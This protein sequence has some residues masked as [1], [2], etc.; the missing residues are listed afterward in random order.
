MGSVPGI[1]DLATELGEPVGA[2]Q[3]ARF[4]S[5]GY[6]ASSIDAAMSLGVCF[7]SSQTQEDIDRSDARMIIEA[8]MAQ[9]DHCERQLIGYGSTNS[10]LNLKS[11][12]S[13][14]PAGCTSRGASQG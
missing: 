1:Q 7:C 9:L 4:A 11:R 3:K 12:K 13:S 6:S 5:Q 8:A 14:V 2:V 10:A